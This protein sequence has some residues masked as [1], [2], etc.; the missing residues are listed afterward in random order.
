MDIQKASYFE[1][2]RFGKEEEFYEKLKLERKTIG[3]LLRSD[4]EGNLLLMAAIIGRNF[5]IAK[6]LLKKR[7]QCQMGDRRRIQ[8]LSSHC[9]T[10]L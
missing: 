8:C 7:S 3:G 10:S 4:S 5:R 2:L 6:A 9:G 1:V